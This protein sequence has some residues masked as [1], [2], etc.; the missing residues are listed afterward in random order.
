MGN[1]ILDS[2]EG[3]MYNRSMKL[4]HCSTCQKQTA[5][6]A[7]SV[8]VAGTKYSDYQLNHVWRC[9]DCD[10]EKPR[11]TRKKAA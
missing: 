6:V 3:V 4:T 1:Y 8:Q 7:I 2:L 9:S 5:H 11:A 10:T